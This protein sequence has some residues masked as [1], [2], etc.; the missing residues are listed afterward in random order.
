MSNAFTALLRKYFGPAE[1]QQPDA[2]E[3]IVG[4]AVRALRGG[5]ETEVTNTMA[6]LGPLHVAE[7]IA[8][9]CIWIEDVTVGRDLD[10]LIMSTTLPLPDRPWVIVDAVNRNDIRALHE[11]A[12]GDLVKLLASMLAV[13]ASLQ[14]AGER[15]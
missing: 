4:A 13:I 2:Y 9:L 10:A 14:E 5:L 3:E 11:W 15:G 12:G 6:S 8:E 7:V 1:P